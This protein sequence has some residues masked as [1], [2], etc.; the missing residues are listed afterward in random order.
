MFP[1]LFTCSNLRLGFLG[2]KTP[3]TRRCS[4]A[5]YAIELS[6]HWWNFA[7]LIAISRE[8][9]LVIMKNVKFRDG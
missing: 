2:K 7:F 5:G 3:R 8:G 9:N 1:A 6:F 4:E